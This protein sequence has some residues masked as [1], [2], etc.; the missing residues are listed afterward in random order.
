MRKK[1]IS[2]SLITLF[3]F[4]LLGNLYILVNSVLNNTFRNGASFAVESIAEAVKAKG[5]VVII[6]KT[7]EKIKL[8]QS[9]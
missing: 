5:E 9:K 1:I 2:I 4:S 6:T 3:C 8:I 7:G